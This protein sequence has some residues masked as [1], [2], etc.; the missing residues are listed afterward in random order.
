MAGERYATK[1][2]SCLGSLP[3]VTTAETL[4]RLL[5]PLNDQVRAS[6]K[7][8]VLIAVLSEANSKVSRSPSLVQGWT[9]HERC[10]HE[11]ETSQPRPSQVLKGLLTERKL[12]AP[13][14]LPI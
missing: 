11:L 10:R 12:L 14:S 8:A 3:N 2:Q 4:L 1:E 13:N 5:L 7:L 6:S 9:D